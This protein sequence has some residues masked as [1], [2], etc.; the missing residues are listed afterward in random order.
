MSRCK[1]LLC[2][3]FFLSACSSDV[4]L[5][6]TGNMPPEEKIEKVKVG[7]TQSQVEEIL[8]SPSAVSTLDS[9]EW[10]YMSSTLKKVAFFKPKIMDRNILAIRFDKNGT[11]TD[12]AKLDKESGR[13]ISIDTDKTE[14]EGHKIGFFKK[15][16]GGVGTYMPIG[17]SKEK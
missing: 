1:V 6:H 5:V 16:F 8:G 4:F 9:N 15:Y 13:Q 3:L 2:G 17:P 11:V 14:S 7:Q 12:I 10:I